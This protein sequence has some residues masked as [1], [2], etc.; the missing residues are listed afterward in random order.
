MLW[1]VRGLSGLQ[2]AYDLFL[3]LHHPS[4]FACPMP[5][6]R[7][8]SL[9]RVPRHHAQCS[10][11]GP[12]KPRVNTLTR[13]AA[14]HPQASLQQMHV[15]DRQGNFPVVRAA[16][17]SPPERVR[18]AYLGVSPWRGHSRLGIRLAR[19]APGLIPMHRGAQSQLHRC[20]PP[21]EPGNP[22]QAGPEWDRA[23]RI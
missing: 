13:E 1:G 17:R 5:G 11:N 4:Q 15:P 9:S 12:A 7:N 3:P 2:G 19:R 16:P 20:S 14:P 18:C 6:S 21:R 22:Q 23:T 10:V 8:L